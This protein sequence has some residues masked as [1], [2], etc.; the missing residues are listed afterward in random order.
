MV[1]P[2][3]RR[4]SKKRRAAEDHETSLEEGEGERDVV[5]AA[6]ALS[7]PYPLPLFDDRVRI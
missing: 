5:E 7:L 4:Y 1:F 6:V 2:H 3:F